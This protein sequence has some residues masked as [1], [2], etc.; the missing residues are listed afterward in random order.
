[1]KSTM[2]E[3]KPLLL[4]VEDDEAFSTVAA[5]ALG[6]RGLEV[7]VAATTA[8]ARDILARRTPDFA[9]VDLRLG[10]E[11][12]LDLV[13]EI[14][15]GAPE[16]RVVILTGYASIAT[17]VRAVKLGAAD[18][19]TKPVGIDELL[20]VLS[21]QAE[22]MPVEPA[23]EPMSVRRASWEHIQRVLQ[24]TDGNVSEAARRLGMH[25]RSLQR[26]LSKRPPP[27]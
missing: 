18:Y 20:G 10:E 14:V 1:M 5:N 23:A 21:P 17:A 3:P 12:G 6:R 7:E 27:R 24:E 11:F 8:A 15:A 9:V 4:L 16:C 19:L 13:P 26:M 2:S 25:R 22:D